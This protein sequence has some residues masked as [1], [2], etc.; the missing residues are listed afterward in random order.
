MNH[1]DLDIWKKSISLVTEIYSVTKDFLKEEMFG[2]ANQIRRAAVSVLSNIAEG[3]ARSSDKEIIRFLDIAAGSLAEPETQLIISEQLGYFQPN[4]LY[5]KIEA[6]G[7]MLSGFK[8]Y[9]KQKV[10]T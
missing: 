9:L 7:Q 5:Q 3:C 10:I 1:K 6:I 4:S 8:R 2:I